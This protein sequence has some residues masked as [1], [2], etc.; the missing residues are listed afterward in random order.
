MRKIRRGMSARQVGKLHGF[1]SGFEDNVSQFLKENNIEHE[2]ETEQISYVKPETKHKYTPDFVLTKKDGSKM[3]IETKGRFVT[4]D[5]KKLQLIKKQYPDL[6]IRLLF[7]NA[8]A[9]LRKGSPTTYAMWAEK[10]GFKYSSGTVVPEEWLK[11]L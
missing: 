10:N 7:Q 6:D 5:R 11:E 2:Y 4:E 3:Y 9:K 8:N 1:R